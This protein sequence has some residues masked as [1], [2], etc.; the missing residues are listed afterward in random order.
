MREII[1]ITALLICTAA[2]GATRPSQ[3]TIPKDTILEI[4]LDAID[5]WPDDYSMQAYVIKQQKEAYQNLY[6]WAIDNRENSLAKIIFRRAQREWPDDYNMQWYIVQREVSALE[7]IYG[8][9]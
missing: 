4:K 3:V 9:E 8:G 1:I 6:A 7:G 5:E 2:I